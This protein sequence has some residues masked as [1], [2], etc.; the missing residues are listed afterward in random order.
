MCILLGWRGSPN[1]KDEPQHL[2]MG[3]ITLDL[4]KLLKI[5][6]VIINNNN[7]ISK[8]I[9]INNYIFYFQ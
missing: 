8:I 1:E 3:K 7:S 6:Y 2:A 5:K 4:L 9:I